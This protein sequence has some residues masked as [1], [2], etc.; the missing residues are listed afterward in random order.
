MPKYPYFHESGFHQ[1][2]TNAGVSSENHLVLRWN[3]EK[4]DYIYDANHKMVKKFGKTE[5]DNF[6]N[7]IKKVPNYDF[8]RYWQQ[9]YKDHWE[10]LQCCCNIYC[11]FTQGCCCACINEAK[12]EY[13]Q[14]M[15][16]RAQAIKGH[17]N[18]QNMNT[19]KVKGLKIN[20]GMYLGY[21]YVDVIDVAPAKNKAAPNTK[22]GSPKKAPAKG[23]NNQPPKPNVVSMQ[24]VMMPQKVTPAPAKNNNNSNQMNNP[25]GPPIVWKY[26]VA[27]NSTINTD[28]STGDLPDMENYIAEMQDSF[29][30]QKSDED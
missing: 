1:E 15:M 12:K 27:Y 30:Y 8:D 5:L 20:H 25:Q 21:M 29:F 9:R 14:K 17:I 22:K 24:P 3:M 19:L 28:L 16:S 7:S 13:Y 6:L 23:N 4:Q 2:M 10:K 11:W 26:E 18:Y